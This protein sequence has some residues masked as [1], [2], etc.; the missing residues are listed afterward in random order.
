M[1]SF[2]VNGFMY[3]LLVR[4]YVLVRIY[5][6]DIGKERNFFNIF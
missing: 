3:Y 5:W 6:I 1:G 2:V 4:G